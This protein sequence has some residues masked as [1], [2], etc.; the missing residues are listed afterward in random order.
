M[1]SKKAILASR[2]LANN[3]G[4]DGNSLTLKV[5]SILAPVVRASS[6]PA[7]FVM[8]SKTPVV[9]SDQDML[10]QTEA[11]LQ[12]FSRQPNAMHVDTHEQ[13][14][15]QL[16]KLVRTS[17]SASLDFARNVVNPVIQDFQKD[18]E[19]ERSYLLGSGLAESQIQM[20]AMQPIYKNEVFAQ[21]Y[22]PLARFYSDATLSRD[23]LNSF[24]DGLTPEEVLEV[25]KLSLGDV[26]GQITS[27]F[28][29]N[30]NEMISDLLHAPHEVINKNCDFGIN[31]ENPFNSHTALFGFLFLNGL[32]NGRLARIEI[33]TLDQKVRNAISSRR[34]YFAK[35]LT[36]QMARFKVILVEGRIRLKNFDRREGGVMMYAVNAVEYRKWLKANEEND[37]DHGTFIAFAQEGR[38][39]EST[40]REEPEVFNQLWKRLETNARR[41]NEVRADNMTN[42]Y[43]RYNLSHHI[44]DSKD[45]EDSMKPE[46]QKRLKKR[47]AEKPYMSSFGLTDYLRQVVCSVLANGTDAYEILT[48]MDSELEKDEELTPKGA[49]VLA[50]CHILA[51]WAANQIEFAEG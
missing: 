7:G 30:L 9:D 39:N 11:L 40:L 31:G 21:V 2:Q 15:S 35:S 12:N 3:A 38:G 45:L 23:L 44:R 4:Y 6:L 17:V 33:D 22:T 27:F 18:I 47:M 34:N 48:I 37:V 42:E 5:G 51:R 43:I 14:L 25:C 19:E 24:V 50:T 8:E 10:T 20:L 41:S 46:L 36:E 29:N 13:E 28:A 1:L 49:A 26:D 16:V 32:L